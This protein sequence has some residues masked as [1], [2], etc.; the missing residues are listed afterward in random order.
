MVTMS[1]WGIINLPSFCLLQKVLLSFKVTPFQKVSCSHSAKAKTSPFGWSA[2]EAFG[3]CW[4]LLCP[5]QQAGDSPETKVTD[6]SALQAWQA[7]HLL[8]HLQQLPW[9]KIAPLSRSD[10]SKVPK[11]WQAGW[12]RHHRTVTKPPKQRI[13]QPFQKVHEIVALIKHTFTRINKGSFHDYQ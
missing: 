7:P 10:I 1:H 9:F 5:C 2:Q 4:C 8:Q 3:C 12:S 6:C 13:L 11:H